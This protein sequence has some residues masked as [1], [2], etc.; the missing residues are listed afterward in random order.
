VFVTGLDEDERGR[1]HL[2]IPNGW[3]DIDVKRS[4]N[5]L[6]ITLSAESVPKNIQMLRRTRAL[7][8]GE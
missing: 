2:W 5:D 1:P 3:L 7:V 6:A 8:H 4:G